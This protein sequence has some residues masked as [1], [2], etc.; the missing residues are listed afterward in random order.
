MSFAP[1]LDDPERLTTTE[2]AELIGRTQS[3]VRA[4]INSHQ[5]PAVRHDGRH[6]VRRD[7]VLAWHQ[8]ARRMK[9][10]ISVRTYEWTAHLL[11]EYHSAS[12]AEL[13]ELTHL[14]PGNVRKHLAILAEQGRVEC[15]PDGQWVLV[16]NPDTGA[17]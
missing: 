1:S 15:R 13:T 5:L 7:D 11:R 16:P 6:Y 4:A 8:K 9:P 12:I 17:A 14:H 3:A 2:A 10:K